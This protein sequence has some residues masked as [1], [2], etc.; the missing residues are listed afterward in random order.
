MG[1]ARKQAALPQRW[2]L[3]MTGKVRASGTHLDVEDYKP[4]SN[5]EPEKFRVTAHNIK[6]VYVNL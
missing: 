2:T 1:F 5:H 6:D 4:P 3:A